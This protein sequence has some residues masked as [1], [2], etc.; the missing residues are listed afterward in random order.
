MDNTEGGEDGKR[1]SRTRSHSVSDISK[2]G[3]FE[4][5]LTAVISGRET[6]TRKNKGEKSR[7]RKLTLL[8]M[9]RNRQHQRQYI[10][11]PSSNS[12]ITPSV[13]RSWFSSL[14]SYD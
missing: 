4:V 10:N 2:V 6:L 11:S 13:K 12:P 5:G 3:D 9:N 8:E 7:F 1:P 14:F